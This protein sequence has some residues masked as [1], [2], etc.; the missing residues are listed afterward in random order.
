[1]QRALQPSTQFFL[2]PISIHIQWSAFNHAIESTSSWRQIAQALV[3]KF[4]LF[5]SFYFTG[6]VGHFRVVLRNSGFT[7]PPFFRLL[8][9]FSESKD[10]VSSPSPPLFLSHSGFSPRVK[11]TLTFPMY[12]TASL[13]KDI[14]KE[15][16]EFKYGEWKGEKRAPE[17]MMSFCFFSLLRWQHVQ[18]LTRI[19]P[20]TLARIGCSPLSL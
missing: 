6:C 1:M 2:L 7:S 18:Q 15:R 14:M 20:A 17:Q 4:F 11:S 9:L 13:Q 16:P 5:P 8:W 19:R 10:F 12:Q 3:S